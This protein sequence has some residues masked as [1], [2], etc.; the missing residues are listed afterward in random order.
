MLYWKGT[1]AFI[2]LEPFNPADKNDS[3]YSLFNINAGK[4]DQRIKQF[5]K[6]AAEFGRPV[7]VSFAHEQN[8]TAYPWGTK[9]AEFKPAFRRMVTMTREQGASNIKWV[10][11]INMDADGRN[12]FEKYF[13]YFPGPDVVDYIAID[14]YVKD[15]SEINKTKAFEKLVF[16][17][18]KRYPT[19]AGRIM[20]GE[21]GCDSLA[22][23][24]VKSEFIKWLINYSASNKM[25]FVYFDF[26]KFEEGRKIYWGLRPDSASLMKDEI[27][28]RKAAF[29]SRLVSPPPNPLIV[30]NGEYQWFDGLS[31]GFRAAR[32]KFQS[33]VRAK[34][35][36]SI[37]SSKAEFKNKYPVMWKAY[38]ARK[39]NDRS[40]P[41]WLRKVLVQP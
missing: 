20:I 8:I 41:D 27:S 25:P 21:T 33:A 24:K 5:G 15:L 29:A 1:A 35:R 3:Q 14:F 39:L 17:L 37:K 13:R 34:D 11:N 36:E 18:Q 30:S 2:K 40:T 19:L 32:G 26:D 31:K 38:V 12:D 28:K 10:W 4:L 23:S 16:T 6:G 22:G 9:P 7:L